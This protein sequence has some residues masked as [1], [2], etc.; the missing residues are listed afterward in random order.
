MLNAILVLLLYAIILCSY[1]YL[2]L[3]K[4]FQYKDVILPEQVFP[5]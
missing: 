5:L 3:I 2:N 1:K 4:S